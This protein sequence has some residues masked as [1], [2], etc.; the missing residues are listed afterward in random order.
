LWLGIQKPQLYKYPNIRFIGL[1]ASASQDIAGK[2]KEW[3]G[4]KMGTHGNSK[5]Y[6]TNNY[7]YH[8]FN[9]G[10]IWKKLIVRY[11]R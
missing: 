1:V 6:I 5:Q 2:A 3:N 8:K 4:G 9:I 7:D 10:E 11:K